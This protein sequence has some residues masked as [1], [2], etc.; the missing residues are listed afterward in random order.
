[1]SIE[2]NSIR[3]GVAHVIVTKTVHKTL[4]EGGGGD[5]MVWV[6]VLGVQRLGFLD[7]IR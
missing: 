5:A 7:A 1:M 4:R 6:Q 3:L 2:W